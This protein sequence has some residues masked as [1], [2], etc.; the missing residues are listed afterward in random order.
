[1]TRGVF[2]HEAVGSQNTEF[3]NIRSYLT[4]LSEALKTPGGL[5]GL[6]SELVRTQVGYKHLEQEAVNGSEHVTEQTT[7]ISK[8]LV[9]CSEQLHALRNRGVVPS[10]QIEAAL[11]LVTDVQAQ[12]NRAAEQTLAYLDVIAKEAATRQTTAPQTLGSTE[13]PISREPRSLN[14]FRQRI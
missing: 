13:A 8:V 2:T 5:R 11:N 10:E 3:S 14:L 12:L 7:K 9:K 6:F 1:G 4:E